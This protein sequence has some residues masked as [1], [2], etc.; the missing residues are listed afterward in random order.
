MQ[1]RM[2]NDLDLAE[3]PADSAI[4]FK[5]SWFKANKQV[6]VSIKSLTKKFIIKNVKDNEL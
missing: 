6:Y 5:A 2:I 4:D 1:Y 3:T